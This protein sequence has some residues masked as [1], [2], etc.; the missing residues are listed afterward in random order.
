MQYLAW[1]H[2]GSTFCILVSQPEKCVDVVQNLEN[3]S[4]MLRSHFE[5]SSYFDVT[6]NAAFN[7]RITRFGSR[8]FLSG[9]F[10]STCGEVLHN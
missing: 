6:S 10:G 9:I 7:A 8:V 1:Y 3:S 4:L 5:K 2:L